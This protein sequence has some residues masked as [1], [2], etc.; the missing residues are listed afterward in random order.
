MMRPCKLTMDWHDDSVRSGH[1]LKAKRGRTAYEVTAIREVE[2][3]ELTGL[4]RFALTCVRWS[5]ADVPDG[6]TVHA[7]HWYK[8]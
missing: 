1:F 3:R 2:R 5:P 4:R 8:R 6:A 7:F